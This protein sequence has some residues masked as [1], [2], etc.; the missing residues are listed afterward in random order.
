MDVQIGKVTHY[1][2][3]IGV[4]IVEVKNQPLKVGDLVRFSGHDNEFSQEIVSLQ[5]EHDKVSEIAPGDS[6]GVKVDK[7]VKAGDVVYLATQ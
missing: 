3:K 7:P 2:D 1:F 5:V 4:A 6:G